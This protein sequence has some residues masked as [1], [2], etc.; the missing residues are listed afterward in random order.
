[1]A[2]HAFLSHVT[3][4]AKLVDRLKS[5]LESGGQIVWLARD[6][7]LPG[8]RWM[9]EIR[10]AISTGTFFIACYSAESVAR[11]ETVMNDE[12][13]IAIEHLRR[14]PLNQRWYIPVKLTPCTIPD[15]DIGG[16]QTL[17][18]I[19]HLEMYPDWNASVRRLKEA[20]GRPPRP[21]GMSRRRLSKR[22]WLLILLTAFTLAVYGVFLLRFWPERS[23]ITATQASLVEQPDD[24]AVGFLSE[25]LAHV[26]GDRIEDAYHAAVS[27]EKAARTDLVRNRA[28]TLRMLLAISLSEGHQMLAEALVGGGN[29]AGAADKLR[30]SEL[31]VGMNMRSLKW[32]K[33]SM[34]ALDTLSSR[35]LP[36]VRF[37]RVELSN[38]L[39]ER[40]TAGLEAHERIKGGKSVP[41]TADLDSALLMLASQ[42]FRFNL[43]KAF[44]AR[45]SRVDVMSKDVWTG[46]VQ[47]SAD[48]AI[49]M[50]EHIIT[51][52]SK[53]AQ[54]V[55]SIEA[56]PPD[57]RFSVGRSFG[58]GEEL[59]LAF[60]HS[61][62]ESLRRF[63]VAIQ[64]TQPSLRDSVDLN[65]LLQHVD[66]QLSTTAGRPRETS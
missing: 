52:S 11:A 38:S 9:S 28:A 58:L 51:M 47:W 23:A 20:L 14:R 32:A 7:M 37:S 57:A 45:A 15:A 19:H 42:A 6:R 4:D 16:G 18:S 54:M 8:D 53:G 61:L 5:D 64:S 41:S 30:Y 49:A 60:C 22:S 50:G 36:E 65:A 1:M 25:A 39:S 46:Q 12:I 29:N 35:K 48:L 55:R 31:A 17:R 33:T 63:A 43:S 62:L 21:E 56:A 34:E 13:L 10:E 26:K 3:E 66:K 59:T 27:A 40:M 2:T 44:E 24:L